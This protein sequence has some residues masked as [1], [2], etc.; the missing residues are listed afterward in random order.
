MRISDRSLVLAV[1]LA[2]FCGGPAAA[3]DPERQPESLAAPSEA[4]K[5]VSD[6]L[7]AGVKGLTDGDKPGA[8]KALQFAATKGNVAA[9]W[10]L[11][12]MY[13]DGDGVPQDDYK[14]F[15]YFSTIANANP[16]EARGTMKA[17]VVAKAF[18]QLGNY[19]LEGIQGSPI[20]SN[21]SRAY[22]M[23][24]YAASFFG[25]AD[26]Q[27]N[28]GRLYL[29]GALGRK[30]SRQAARWLNLAAEKGHTPSQ[31]V[32]GQ[33]LFNG[34]D[35]IPRQRALGLSWMYMARQAA[36]GSKDI[37]IIEMTRSAEEAC[38]DEERQLASHY[39]RK[40]SR[41]AVTAIAPPAALAAP[42]RD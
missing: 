37:W 14:A 4:F 20:K 23:F 21:P 32:L 24:H 6:A 22:E 5:S 38:S 13:A 33:M 36:D 39:A 29:D 30:D 16:E 3:F 2:A 31:A 12:R 42:P 17:G 25:D 15:Q 1:V 35:G 8:V 34:K 7:R 27:Y 28:L 41:A 18:V 26:A 11:G 19:F 9:Q 10:K 40:S